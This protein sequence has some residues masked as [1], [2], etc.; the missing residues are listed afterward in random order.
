[1][2]LQ[3]K[4]QL[5]GTVLKIKLAGAVIDIGTGKPAVL[6]ISQV[7]APDNKPF[8]SVTEVLTEGQKIEVWV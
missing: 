2:D 3:P 4:M 8:K 5:N 7:V 1:M 6:H